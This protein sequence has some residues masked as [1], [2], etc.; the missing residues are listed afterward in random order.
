MRRCIKF[1]SFDLSNG[2]TKKDPQYDIQLALQWKADPHLTNMLLNKNT[3]SAYS[4][5]DGYH[6]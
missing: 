6:D 2:I 4:G 1:C 3:T 5:N